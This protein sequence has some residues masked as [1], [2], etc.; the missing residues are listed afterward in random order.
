MNA[1]L[2]EGVDVVFCNRGVGRA[3][4][5]YCLVREVV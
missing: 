5:Q 4:R 2:E 1:R 3:R